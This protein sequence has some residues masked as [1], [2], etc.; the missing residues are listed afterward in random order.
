MEVHCEGLKLIT[1]GFLL[2]FPVVGY[3]VGK[4]VGD[5]GSKV[6][7]NVV[8]VFVGFFITGFEVGRLGRIVGS[9][10]VIKMGA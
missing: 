3:D 4:S 1:T 2:G 5:V 10:V 8:G 7:E 9:T 6:G